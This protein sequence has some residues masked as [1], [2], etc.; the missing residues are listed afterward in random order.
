MSPN[1]NASTPCH[2]PTECTRPRIPIE[3]LQEANLPSSQPEPGWVASRIQPTQTSTGRNARANVLG[4]HLTLSP[5]VQ[6]PTWFASASRSPAPATIAIAIQKRP[7]VCI[8]TWEAPQRASPASAAA[9]ASV[10]PL[11]ASY[12]PYLRILFTS[13]RC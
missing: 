11:D 4:D 2:S 1:P 10:R 3:L 12:V 8:P 5:F 13:F 9:R 6:V 7:V